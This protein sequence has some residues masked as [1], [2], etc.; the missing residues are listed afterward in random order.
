MESLL[1]ADRSGIDRWV[2]RVNLLAKKMDEEAASIHPSA[3]TEAME[4]ENEKFR[5]IA[6]SLPR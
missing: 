4:K 1:M 5:K 2:A 6:K 3:W